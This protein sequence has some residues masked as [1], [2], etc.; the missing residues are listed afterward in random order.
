V[1]DQPLPVVTNRRERVVIAPRRFSEFPA[2]CQQKPRIKLIQYLSDQ[3]V[4]FVDERA[5]G[6][7]RSAKLAFAISEFSPSRP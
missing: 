2:G 1:R 6:S 3:A 5:L 4:L 7:F